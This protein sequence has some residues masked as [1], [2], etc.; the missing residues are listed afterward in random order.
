MPQA[1]LQFNT[2]E[3][4]DKRMIA[5]GYHRAMTMQ[6]SCLYMIRKNNERQVIVAKVN[7]KYTMR[8]L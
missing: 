7:D 2:F 6:D 5:N 8:F 3:Q 1:Q 4:A